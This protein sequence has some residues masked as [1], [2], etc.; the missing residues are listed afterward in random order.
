[1]LLNDGN[2]GFAEKR[3]Y[4]TGSDETRSAALA[5]LNGDGFLDIV[6]ANIGEPNG[7]YLGDGSGG[8]G[9]GTSVGG[10]EESYAL[11]LLDVEQDGDIDVVVANVRGPNELY[12]NDGSGTHWTRSL[13]GEQ[14]DITYGVAAA[15]VNGDGFTDVGFAN[16]AGQN[17]IFLNIEARRRRE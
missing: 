17:L 5:D 6:N 4:G 9:Q 8:F 16:S 14:A 10:S 11:A 13:I 3:P 12:R 1:V 2:L 7:I 15:D